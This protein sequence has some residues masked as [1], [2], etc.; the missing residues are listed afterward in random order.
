MVKAILIDAATRTISKIKVDP[1][2]DPGRIIGPGEIG[3]VPVGNSGDYLFSHGEEGHDGASPAF[4]FQGVNGVHYA[5]AIV[6]GSDDEG[7]DHD[8][9]FSCA[10]VEAMV[11]WC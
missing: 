8:V 2:A 4:M 5:K 9:T 11:R 10:E 6:V 1:D 3:W 7:H